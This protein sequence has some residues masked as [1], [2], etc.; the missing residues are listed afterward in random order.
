MEKSPSIT[1]KSCMALFIGCSDYKGKIKPLI[2]PKEDVKAVMTLFEDHMDYFERSRKLN[3]TTGQINELFK[4]DFLSA[5][6]NAKRYESTALFFIYYSGHGVMNGSQTEGISI[7]G[8]RI[9]LDQ[10][11]KELS[12]YEN[13]FTLALFDCCRD[14][15]NKPEDKDQ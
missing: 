9:P 7:D 15:L 8:S 1:P 13:T 11:V 6:K 10:Y 14:I 3:Q 2:G 5:A 12:S 4:N